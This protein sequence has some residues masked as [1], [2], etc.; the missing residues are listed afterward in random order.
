MANALALVLEWSGRRSKVLPATVLAVFLTIGFVGVGGVINL[1]VI[2]LHYLAARKCPSGVH[3][4]LNP[5]TSIVPYLA[6]ADAN[7]S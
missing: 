7:V 5:V 3:Y 6:S 1:C 4:Q 2:D